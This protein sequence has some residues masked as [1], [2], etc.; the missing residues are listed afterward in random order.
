MTRFTAASFAF[1][2]VALSHCSSNGDAPCALAQVGATCTL[3]TD[4]CTGYCQLYE[5][6][7]TACQTKPKTPQA[8]VAQGDLCTQNRN[9]CSGLCDNGTCFGGSGGTSCLSLGSSCI[10]NDSCCSNECVQDGQGHSDCAPQPQSDGGLN[11]GLPGAACSTPG[12][13]PGECCFG[14]C[15]PNGQCASGGGGGGGGQNC[16]QS[17]AYCKYGSDCCSGQCETLSSTSSCH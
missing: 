5:D 12:E 7:T 13:D 4:C 1:V 6:S 8:C 9:C 11:C 16:G 14:L 2:V 15:G 17:G 10:Q 3:D